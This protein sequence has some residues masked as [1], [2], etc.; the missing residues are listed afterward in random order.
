MPKLRSLP[1]PPKKAGMKWE[2]FF[3]DEDDKRLLWGVVQEFPDEGM[4]EDKL[5]AKIEALQDHMMRIRIEGCMIDLFQHGLVRL[6]LS[7]DGSILV[8]AAGEAGGG[9]DLR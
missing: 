5:F 3:N 9:A 1:P 7:D 6:G 2:D 8:Q 4:E